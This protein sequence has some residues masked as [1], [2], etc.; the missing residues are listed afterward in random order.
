MKKYITS[1]FTLLIFTIQGS[2]A[3]TVWRGEVYQPM[4]IKEKTPPRNNQFIS[5]EKVVTYELANKTE[6][7]LSPVEDTTLLAPHRIFEG[8][9]TG[10]FLKLNE[11]GFWEKNFTNLARASDIETYPLRT[12]VK[13]FMKFPSGNYECSGTLIDARFVLTAGHC[14]YDEEEGEWAESIEVVPAYERG[15]APFGAA[16]AISLYSWNGWTENGD[17]NWDMG[18]IKLNRPIGGITGW[19]GF[20]YNDNPAF[21]TT[22]TFH[23]PGYPVETPYDGEY[24]YYWYGT[25]DNIPNENLANINKYSYGGQSGSGAH[26]QN[27]ESRRVHAILSHGNATSTGFVRLNDARFNSILNRINENT[28]A[29]PDLIPLRLTIEPGTVSAGETLTDFRFLI[30]NYSSESFEGNIKADVYLSDDD[31]I[32]DSDNYITSLNYNNIDIDPKGTKTFFSSDGLLIP[33]NVTSGEYFIG[34][35]LNIEDAEEDNNGMESWDVALIEIEGVSLSPDS[36]E[37]NNS[38]STARTLNAS[39]SGNSATVK[40]SGA[41]IHNISDE[42]FYKIVL[43]AGYNYT[44]YARLQDDFESD[45]DIEYTLDA[46]FAIDDGGGWSDFEDTELQED[47]ILNNGG[48]VYFHVRPYD[49]EEETGTYALEVEIQRSA[50]NT[51]TVSPESVNLS[52]SADA[53]TISVASN[54]NWTVNESLDWLSVSPSSGSNNGSFSI[55][56]QANTASTSRS[57]S[58]IVTGGNI[59]RTISITQQGASAILALSTASLNFTATGGNQSA[60][61]TS[62]ISW[63]ATSNQSWATVS[64]SSGS[65]NATITINSQTNATTTS[66]TAIITVAGSGQS[67]TISIT[68]QG[69]ATIL[70]LSPASLTFNASGGNQSIAVTSNLNWTASSNETWLT[71][72]PLIGTNNG[73]L[74][75]TCLANNTISPRS[76]I[77]TVK[78]GS[79]LRTV[80]VSQHASIAALTLTPTTLDFNATG[81][82]QSV[83][84]S[85]NINWTASSSQPW[86]TMNPASGTNDGTLAVNCQANTAITSRTAVITVSGSD[87]TRTINV[88]QQ[89][90]SIITPWTE[91]PTGESHT[92]ILQSTLTSDIN[93]ASLAVGDYIGFFYEHNGSLKC[94]GLKRWTG[95]NLALSAYGNDAAGSDKNGFSIGEVFKIKVYRAATAQEYNVTGTFAPPNGSSIT[96]TNAYENDGFSVLTA[97]STSSAATLSVPLAAGWNM[98]SSNVIPESPDLLQVINSI[99]DKVVIM[100]N[101]AEKTTIPAYEINDIGN[102]NI[103]EGYKI[104]L[105]QAATLAITGSKVISSAH[106]I[107]IKP[108]WQIIACLSNAPIPIEQVLGNYA[109]QI[110]IVKDNLTRSYIPEFGI[111]EIGNLLPTQGYKLKAKSGFTITYPA[112]LKDEEVIIRAETQWHNAPLQHF[113]INPALNT[114]SSATIILPLQNVTNFLQAQD[115]I[116][117]FTP[118]GVLCGAGV[119]ENKNL[120]ITAWGDDP[121]TPLKEGLQAGEA[122]HFKLW[123]AAT[124][125]EQTAQVTYASGDPIYHEDDV[126][127]VNSLLLTTSVLNENSTASLRVEC[128]PNPANDRLNVEIFHAGHSVQIQLLTIDGKI[129][130]D[131][132][133]RIADSKHTPIVLDISKVVAGFYILQVK[134]GQNKR[135]NKIAVVK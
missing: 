112:N 83:T 1:I 119:F 100:K 79:E 21:Y 59:S 38:K 88:T 58:I 122:Y 78:S 64:P 108:G 97:L 26:H 46:D 74:T 31:V 15:E 42:D 73:T 49:G 11:E 52:A 95:S 9:D 14:I 61:V 60:T 34:V 118:D 54:V 53:K 51:L 40:T 24:M 125:V 62:N 69:A 87:I 44:V 33:D 127:I 133:N 45:D 17:Y 102:W 25:F 80:T 56:A 77:I 99:Q 63:T 128:Y 3:Q 89:A 81:G 101:G 76:A 132:G 96:H 47:L 2:I 66:R 93:G 82:N 27:S 92:I 20:G 91:T 10:K 7:L 37:A 4:P 126:E 107:E 84:V 109:T 57:G 110:Q 90:A 131:Y 85:S 48:T 123:K 13:I 135:I 121:T 130:Q 32:D 19:L 129:L 134:D 39:F 103:K 8:I 28:P 68:Q 75:I 36:Y 23:N 116:G 106:P 105:S 117:I 72:A 71:V 35:V 98:I 124:N 111:N 86:V 50:S 22:N 29:E 12:N 6:R 120:A 16:T 30:H 104:K 67:K 115:E 41:N 70:T 18:Y 43:P 5:G 113:L 114:G 94:G 55:N 65:G